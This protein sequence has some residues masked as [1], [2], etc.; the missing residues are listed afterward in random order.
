MDQIP[1]SKI[2]RGNATTL[3]DTVVN[4]RPEGGALVLF[5]EPGAK[6]KAVNFRQA[7]YRLRLRERKRNTVRLPSGEIA[8]GQITWDSLGFYVG[9]AKKEGD[10]YW[11]LLCY[12]TDDTIEEVTCARTGEKIEWLRTKND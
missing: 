8:P 5:S 10:V 7:C 4:E 9:S 6:G 1:S 3:M 12:H 2:I 11:Y